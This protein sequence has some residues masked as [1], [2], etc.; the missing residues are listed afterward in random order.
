M[1][2]VD[3]LSINGDPNVGLYAIATDKFCIVG[4]SVSQKL[5][6]RLEEVLKVPVIQANIY[7][8]GFLGLFVAATSKTVL[9]PAVI[10]ERELKELKVALKGLA[11]VK[12]L[13]TEHTALNNNILNNDKVAI[14][15]PEFS[16]QEVRDIEKALKVKVLQ[17][18]LA[19]LEVPGSAGV[20]SN[21]GAIFNPNLKDK[22]IKQIEKLLNF[23]IGLGTVNMGSPIVSSGLIANSNG[24]I[25]GDLTSGYE[26]SR[27]DESLGFL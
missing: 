15:S 14:L 10:F 7:G 4:K 24:F 3:K 19:D 18:S 9:V 20:I 2:H 11:E 17:T 16:K 21:K 12:I 22:E 26:I 1:P 23:E 25:I 6:K 27:V 8:T 5:V 13:N